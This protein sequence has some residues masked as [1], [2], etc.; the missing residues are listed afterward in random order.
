MS[1]RASVKSRRRFLK[2][3]GLAG[4]ALAGGFAG[5]RRAW[6][7]A[8]A[9]PVTQM[10]QTPVLTIGY[11]DNGDSRGFP[12]ILLHGFPDDVRAWDEVTPPLVRAGYRVLVPY[13]RGYGPT[14]FRDARA[15]RMAQQAAIGQDLIDLADALRLP[16]FAAAGYDW[17]GRAAGIAAALH[18]DR[19]RAA[20]LIGGYTIQNTVAPPR[21]AA[22]ETERALWYQ[23]YFNTERGRAGLSSNRRG[24]CRLLWET[25]SPTWHF[26]DDTFNRTAAS[27]DNPDFVDV[28]IHS[29]RHRNGNATGEERFT[30]ME[31]RLALR[32]QIE[33][34][35]IVLYGGDDGIAR[36]AADSPA[37]RASFTSLVARRVVAGAGHFLPREKPGAVASAMLELL[38]ATR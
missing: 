33:V 24:I 27:F 13:L 17:G 11:E 8:I 10:V 37:E 35:S 19:V 14:R 22:P 36:P 34:P 32:P 38:T 12:V 28:V 6:A 1:E 21:P 26:S 29:Y 4:T 5:A 9:M 31:K 25:W 2:A 7:Q 3:T 20:V 30:D 15:P 23:W 18:P 16:R